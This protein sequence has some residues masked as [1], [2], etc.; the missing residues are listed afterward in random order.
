MAG[1]HNF[2]AETYATIKIILMQVYSVRSSL[3]HNGK[4]NIK[5]SITEADKD[6]ESA[7]HDD[8]DFER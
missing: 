7:L 1:R 8:G 3:C 5:T 4:G 2:N 6:V